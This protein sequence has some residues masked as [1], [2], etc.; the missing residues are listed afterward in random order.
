MLKVKNFHLLL[1]N[2]CTNVCGSKNDQLAR[3]GIMYEY[4]SGKKLS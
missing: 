1:S 3:G 4:A 2:C